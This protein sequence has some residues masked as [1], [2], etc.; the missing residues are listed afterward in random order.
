M[1]RE[2]DKDQEAPEGEHFSN[3]SSVHRVEAESS[4][5]DKDTSS[6]KRKMVESTSTTTTM[7][8]KETA[9]SSASSAVL[10][11]TS[12]DTGSNQD[13]WS[14]MDLSTVE[15]QQKK[16]P[17]MDLEEARFQVR[18]CSPQ[19]WKRQK[20]T[21]AYMKIFVH[22]LTDMSKYFTCCSHL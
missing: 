17:S 3:D 6:R 12:S 9:S 1:Q 20:V 2:V 18:P 8:K 22:S 13:Q 7:A 10:S 5:S 16:N 11:K 19:C 21:A 15:G 14:A 4:M